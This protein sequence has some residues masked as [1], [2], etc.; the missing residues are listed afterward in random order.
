MKH[1]E[2]FEE[3]LPQEEKIH[4][5][6]QGGKKKTTESF[7]M[8]SSKLLC[9]INILRTIREDF[10]SIKQEQGGIKINTCETN[11][12]ELLEM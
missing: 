5:N 7:L 6:N 3:N 2:T 11:K 4:Q 8:F 9:W 1:N 12:K 10:I